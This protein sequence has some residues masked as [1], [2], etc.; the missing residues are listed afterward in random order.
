VVVVLVGGTAR[1]THS[2]SWDW[3]RG[4]GCV[5]LMTATGTTLMTRRWREERRYNYVFLLYLC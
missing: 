5:R 1:E 2:V 4:T 3:E